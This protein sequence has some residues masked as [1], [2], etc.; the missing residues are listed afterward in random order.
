MQQGTAGKRDLCGC[1]SG[2]ATDNGISR[3]AEQAA[4]RCV[5]RGKARCLH[6]SEPAGKGGGGHAPTLRISRYAT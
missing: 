2:L 5:R 6:L 3:H 4:S 1:A